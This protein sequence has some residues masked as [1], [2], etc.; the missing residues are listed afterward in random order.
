MEIYDSIKVKNR[1]DAPRA[2]KDLEE[3]IGK[4]AS[5]R[6][7]TSE[8][9]DV[10]VFGDFMGQGATIVLQSFNTSKDYDGSNDRPAFYRLYFTGVPTAQ[11]VRELAMIEDKYK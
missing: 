2:R 8:S 5:C 9:H 3:L 1:V 4:Y 10:D 6:L 7:V 11:F